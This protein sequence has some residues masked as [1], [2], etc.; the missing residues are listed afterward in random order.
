MKKI[1]SIIL[2]IVML[3]TMLVGCGSKTGADETKKPVNNAVIESEIDE[4]ENEDTEDSKDSGGKITMEK[5]MGHPESPEEDF[6]CIKYGNGDVALEGYLGDDEIVVIPESLGITHIS[7]YVFANNSCV[8]AIRLSNSVT[9]IDD[10]AF[11]LNEN[12]ELV[13]CGSGLRELGV[14]AF[15][16]CQNLREI[17]LN[18]GLEK[19]LEFSLSG[20]DVM[21]S[22]D[23]PATVTEIHYDA[24]Y[25][26]PEGFYIIGEAGSA[27][28]EFA[29][30]EGYTFKTK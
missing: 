13:V 8:K 15:Q 14:S 18:D 26:L 7:S 12:L 9:V 16:N 27:A 22:V 21:M 3:C 28:E 5:L 4:K 17:V 2:I 10:Y 20:S 30:A 24:F 19:M 6:K 1:V 11:A 23:I 29:T 25:S